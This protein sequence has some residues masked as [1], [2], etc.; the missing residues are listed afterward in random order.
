M[1]AKALSHVVSSQL[2]TLASPFVALP[3]PAFANQP[4]M[5]APVEELQF[6]ADAAVCGW[7]SPAQEQRTIRSTT[8]V[9]PTRRLSPVPSSKASVTYCTARRRLEADF[10]ADGSPGQAEH[11]PSNAQTRAMLGQPN[12]SQAHAHHDVCHVIT[13]QQLRA[14]HWA[15]PHE[16]AGQ[17][18]MP[19]C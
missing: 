19:D 18:G 15:A 1:D 4:G 3:G 16:P 12:Q 5:P 17:R 2:C 7:R 11:C 6:A 8:I 14:I 10:G 13:R 9:A